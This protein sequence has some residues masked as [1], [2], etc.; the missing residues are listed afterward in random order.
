MAG[1]RAWGCPGLIAISLALGLGAATL[2]PAAV[3]RSYF[4]VLAPTEPVI[5]SPADLVIAIAIVDPD[6]QVDPATVH[7][8]LDGRDVTALAEI[9]P[10][11]VT[12][13][14][15]LALRP[16]AHRFEIS[17]RTLTGSEVAPVRQEFRTGTEPGGEVNRKVT[18]QLAIDSMDDDVSGP[19]RRLRQE[20]SHTATSR[21]ALGTKWNDW[22]LEGLVYL[23]TD[24]NQRFQPRNRYAFHIDRD[25]IGLDAGDMNYSFS[26]FV[27]QGKRSRG[28]G[29]HLRLG[30]VE[31]TALAGS[32]RRSVDGSVR[33]TPGEI[34]T[35]RTDPSDPDTL[36]VPADT[37]TVGG[38]FERN[39]IGARLAFG[40]GRTFRFGLDGLRV[41]D[42]VGSIP[43]GLLPKDNLVLGGDVYVAPAGRRLIAEATWAA[44]ALTNDITGGAASDSLIELRVGGDVPDLR[45]WDDFIIVNPSTIPLDPRRLSNLAWEAGVKGR[46]AS[47]VY[48][49]RYRSVGSAFHSL[50]ATSLR[51][52]R[53][54]FRLTDV[55]HTLDRQLELSGEYEKFADNLS[56]DKLFTTDTRIWG[57]SATFVP[58]RGD[59]K[60]LALGLRRYGRQN[61]A[62]TPAAGGLDLRRDDTTTTFTVGTGYHLGW[63]PGHELG[64][65]YL[66][67]NT[68]AR[69]EATEAVQS[70]WSADWSTR[71]TKLPVA[72]KASVG[73]SRTSYPG[74]G[75]ELTYQNYDLRGA[76]RL[77]GGRLEADASAALTAG[78]GSQGLSAGDKLTWSAGTRYRLRTGTLVS[79]RLGMARFRDAGNPERDYDERIISVRLVQELA[80]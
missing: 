41:R 16:G 6:R 4:F 15:D 8:L 73:A 56:R 32:I 9:T 61:D 66:R 80:L 39:I 18:G 62:P 36:E 55:F 57:A 43:A 25:W 38:T 76:Y 29:G 22:R 28:F 65:R 37:T 3:G 1:S 30:A 47:N 13:V 52:D 40:R 71:F 44:S 2:S 10:D 17:A 70:D 5:S 23:T 58:G 33:I 74:T 67:S 7:L 48:R 12:Y 11:A 50:A 64:L 35:L 45:N 59:F 68:R 72:L 42:D 79:G 53:A 20:P 51:N 24:E 75:A 46:V 63:G 54:G 77:L 34:D 19:G 69:Q 31:V 78:E 21:L 26:P 27:L 49:V 60:H 14:P